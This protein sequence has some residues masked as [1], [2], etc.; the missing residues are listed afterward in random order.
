MR[1]ALSF[2]F[3]C[4]FLTANNALGQETYQLDGLEVTLP[5]GFSGHSRMMEGN[6]N[7]G[8]AKE[9]TT[10]FSQLILTIT[11][12]KNTGMDGV[13]TDEMLLLAKD[14]ILSPFKQMGFTCGPTSEYKFQKHRGFKVDAT[15][16]MADIPIKITMK[17]FLFAQYMVIFQEWYGEDCSAEYQTIENSLRISSGNEKLSGMQTISKEGYCFTYDADKLMASSKKEDGVINF[18][19][20]CKDASYGDTFIQFD[21][22]SKSGEN[23]YGDAFTHFDTLVDLITKTYAKI[24]LKPMEK[25]TFLGKSGYMRTGLGQIITSGQKVKF[26]YKA[27]NYNGKFTLGTVQQALNA[28]GQVPKEVDELFKAVEASLKYSPQ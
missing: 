20:S 15:G 4:L 25:T 5:K 27:C 7:A 9:G 19:F 24:D 14:N 17:C 23:L 6:L 2:L 12:L 10:P 26:T 18:Y 21:F 3:C 8:F 22:Y 1:T 16:T 11:D 13:I 28:N